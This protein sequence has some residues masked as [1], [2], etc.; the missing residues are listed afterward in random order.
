[1]FIHSRTASIVYKLVLALLGAAA[2]LTELGV[3]DNS[4]HVSFLYYFTN[5]SNIA[6]VLYLFCAAIALI[7]NKDLWPLP[8]HPSAA[9]DP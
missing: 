5:I 3:F 4:V 2:L 9:Q 7:R 6:V 1:M 8:W